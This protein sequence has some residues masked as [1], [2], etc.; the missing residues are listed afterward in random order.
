MSNV[1]HMNSFQFQDYKIGRRR[2]LKSLERT[3]LSEAEQ[4][5]FALRQVGDFFRL[6]RIRA[7]ISIEDAATV[8]QL[9][10][11]ELMAFEQGGGQVPARSIASLCAR[12]GVERDFEE[13]Y[14][15]LR[16]AT[17]PEEMAAF[18]KVRPILEKMGL[19]R[20]KDW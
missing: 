10:K 11:D 19:I 7:G 4:I 18:L 17:R 5:P 1:I 14:S 8:I 9:S 6:A 15:Y 12:Y 3:N 2:L 20:P 16:G 13:F